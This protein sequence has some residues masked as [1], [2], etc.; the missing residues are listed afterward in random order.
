MTEPD[1]SLHDTYYVVTRPS[2]YFSFLVLF[3]F[4]ALAYGAM[5]Q[6]RHKPYRQ[7]LAYSHF[8]LTLIGTL[9]ILS[10]PVVINVAGLAGSYEDPS[11]SFA[12]ANTAMSAG[13]GLVLVAQLIF[14]TVLVDAYLI[15]RR[16]A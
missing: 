5:G 6:V 2:L 10:V 9:L 1:A 11:R 8:G 4:F 15:R 14:V 16:P 7:P 3:L 12:L 13:Y